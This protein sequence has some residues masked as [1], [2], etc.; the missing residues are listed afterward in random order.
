MIEA[1]ERSAGSGPSA[2][3][4]C[5][6]CGH[7]EY[8][9]CDYERSRAGA[10]HPNEGQ[11]VHRMTKRGWSF[12]KGRLRCLAC[13]VARKGGQNQNDGQVNKEGEDMAET[14]VIEARRPTRE[15]KRQIVE[16]LGDVYNT[17]DERYIGCESDITVAAAIGD[18]CMFGW[19]AEIREEL[20]GPD[21]RNEE[22]DAL[23]ASII[24]WQEKTEASISAAKL[25]IEGMEVTRAEVEG[26]KRR[27]DAL[28][29]AAGPRAR[30]K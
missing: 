8:E 4:R 6:D 13:E 15:Q 5:D 24:D 26:M 25:A 27:L 3:V 21:G 18:G 9:R 16:M 7:A 19:V 17:A 12:I 29:K 2:I 20:F 10:W 14:A 1:M 11:I 30:A 23:A 22:L 28:V